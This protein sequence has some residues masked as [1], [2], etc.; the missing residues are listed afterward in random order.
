MSCHYPPSKPNALRRNTRS[1]DSMVSNSQMLSEMKTALWK[2]IRGREM[3]FKITGIATTDQMK[4][5]EVLKNHVQAYRH[6]FTLIGICKLILKYRK[7]IELIFPSN[8]VRFRKQI[9]KWQQLFQY[10]QYFINQNQ[11]L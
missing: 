8:Q 6:S 4:A 9:E 2:L 11:R 10:A 3:A 5:I 1:S 7:E